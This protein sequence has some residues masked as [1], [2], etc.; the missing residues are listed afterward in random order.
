[1]V[2]VEVPRPIF[3][4]IA[5]STKRRTCR[6]SN[7]FGPMDQID[8]SITRQPIGTLLRL[9]KSSVLRPKK[10]VSDFRPPRDGI[11]VSYDAG[12]VEQHYH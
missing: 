5:L 12:D 8:V 3:I 2:C 10:A 7:T 4:R 9:L 6:A 11:D 1:M